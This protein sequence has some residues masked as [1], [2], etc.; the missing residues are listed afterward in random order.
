MFYTMSGT[1][2]P[3][4]GDIISGRSNFGRLHGGVKPWN[5]LEWCDRGNPAV[6]SVIV[7]GRA[8][9]ENLFS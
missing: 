3:Q 9:E 7:V 8:K 5:R 4:Q 1:S 6:D 2:S